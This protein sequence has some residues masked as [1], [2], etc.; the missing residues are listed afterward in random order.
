MLLSTKVLEMAPKAKQAPRESPRKRQKTSAPAVVPRA[1]TEENSTAPAMSA[2]AARNAT[3]AAAKSDTSDTDTD[4]DSEH[5]QEAIP[6]DDELKALE[7]SSASSAEDDQP[8]KTPKLKKKSLSAGRYFA[9][10]DSSSARNRPRSV[11]GAP[12]PLREI[13]TFDN[14][15]GEAIGDAQEQELEEQKLPSQ[16]KLGRGKR[17]RREKRSAVSHR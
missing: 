11:A 12:E 9:G 4:E 13:E 8:R 6:S 1:S 15:D 3:A 16:G 14:D 17:Q 2:K 10:E 7:E 5:E